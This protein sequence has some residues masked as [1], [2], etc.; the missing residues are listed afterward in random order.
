VI[1]K[2]LTIVPNDDA[3]KRTINR[4]NEHRNFIRVEG[5]EISTNVSGFVG[6]KCIA[7]DCAGTHKSDCGWRGWIPLDEVNLTILPKE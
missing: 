5:L 7:V 1:V 2:F 4:C 3:S 6:R